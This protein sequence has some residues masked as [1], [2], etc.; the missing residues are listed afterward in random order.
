MMPLRPTCGVPVAMVFS[1]GKRVRGGRAAAT[2]P[3]SPPH[4]HLQRA[5]RLLGRALQPLLH[6]VHAAVL[7]QKPLQLVAELRLPETDVRQPLAQVP[8]GALLHLLC[9]LVLVLHE[10]HGVTH[11]PA[12]PQP[13]GLGP[14]YLQ[15]VGLVPVVGAIAA[16]ECRAERGQ[17]GGRP[18]GAAARGLVILAGLGVGDLVEEAGSP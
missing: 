10:P 6:R 17:D 16:E 15:L 5:V 2:T 3:A 8:T 18:Q 4:A 14:A 11:E 13:R 9:Q 7:V 1:E 12:G